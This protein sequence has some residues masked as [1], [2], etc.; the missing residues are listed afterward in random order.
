MNKT[1]NQPRR[2]RGGCEMSSVRIRTRTTRA[3]PDRRY[4]VAYRIGGRYGRDRSAGTF[5]RLTGAR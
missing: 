1:R 5:P 2:E 3:E 4:M